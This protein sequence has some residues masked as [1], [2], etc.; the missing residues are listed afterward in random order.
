MN[1]MEN[2]KN[3]SKLLFGIGTSIL[4][5]ILGIYLYSTKA[6]T[7]NTSYANFTKIVGISCIL[8]FGII[9]LISLKKIISK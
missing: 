4:F 9:V 7:I 8:F 1:N 5:I 6:E 2:K 3:K